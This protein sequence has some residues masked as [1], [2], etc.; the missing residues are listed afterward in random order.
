MTACN[1]HLTDKHAADLSPWSI[2]L[3][4]QGQAAVTLRGSVSDDSARWPGEAH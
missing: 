2:D 4:I 3:R 1:M